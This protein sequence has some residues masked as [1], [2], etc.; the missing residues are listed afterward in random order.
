MPTMVEADDGLE[1]WT[2][3]VG[4]S[5]LPQADHFMLITGLDL[6]QD[7]DNNV[8]G[9]AT[10]GGICGGNR[11][12]FMQ[13]STSNVYAHELGHNLGSYH[14]GTYDSC[15]GEDQYVMSAISEPPVNTT[16][17]HHWIFSKCS[18][19]YFDSFLQVLDRQ[20]DE[21]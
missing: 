21:T 14:D 11:T 18:V 16:I 4:T 10:I 3:W 1:R 2:Q 9:I 20:V 7:G 17:G 12:S 8:D 15:N 6:T 19:E 13:L 5:S